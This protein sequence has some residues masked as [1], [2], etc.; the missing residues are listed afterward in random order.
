M[1]VR[2]A[3]KTRKKSWKEVR[4]VVVSRI[5]SAAEENSG[6]ILVEAITDSE[7]NWKNRRL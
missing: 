6:F 1:R 7:C 3:G 4:D 2:V 5:L